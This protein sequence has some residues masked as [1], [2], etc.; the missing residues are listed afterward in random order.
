MSGIDPEKTLA[1]IFELHDAAKRMEA[2]CEAYNSTQAILGCRPGESLEM[3]AEAMMQAK[4][5]VEKNASELRVE[6]ENLKSRYSDDIKKENNSLLS[7][8]RRIKTILGVA[9]GEGLE[10]ACQS[11]M[12][13]LSAL[14]LQVEELKKSQMPANWTFSGLAPVPE[15]TEADLRAL[16]KKEFA[17]KE[18]EIERLRKEV[19]LNK[20]QQE[21]LLRN[22]NNNLVE[23]QKLKKELE[24]LRKE[25]EELKKNSVTWS[26]L[27]IAEGKAWTKNKEGE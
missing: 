12:E 15:T 1:L 21:N 3:A 8:Y 13:E 14:R 9:D 27:S 26:P 17:E 10:S 7:L 6:L 5:E 4:E 24:L 18:A 25:N 16:F 20:I 19:A 2:R 22:D 23:I 11:R